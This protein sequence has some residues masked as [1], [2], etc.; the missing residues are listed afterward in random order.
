MGFAPEGCFRGM[1]TLCTSWSSA[2]SLLA[3][4]AL[5]EDGRMLLLPSACR[6]G[7]GLLTSAADPRQKRDGKDSVLTP[8]LWPG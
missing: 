8:L 5:S 2:K 3:S 1:A 4:T 6:E 7:E